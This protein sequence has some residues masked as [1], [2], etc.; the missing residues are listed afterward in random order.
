M[1]Q[2]WRW[3]QGRLEYFRFDNIRIIAKCLLNME[4]ANLNDP[5]LDPLRDILESETGLPFAPSHYKVWR[6]YGRV[7]ACSLLAT[8]HQDLL[9][10]TDLCRRVAGSETPALTVDEY[11]SFIIPR[12]YFPSPV[13]QGYSVSNPQIFPFCA[14]L[15]YL[16]AQFYQRGEANINIDEVF[17]LI[18][19]N[20]DGTENIDF[21]SNLSPSNLTPSGDLKRQ[22]REMLIFI[23]Q[24][25]FLKWHQNALFLDIMPEDSK[26]IEELEAL[27]IPVIKERN[28]SQPDEILAIGTTHDQ[29][30]IAP[31]LIGTRNL[32]TDLIFTEGKQVRVEHIR[33]ERSP[34]LRKLYF[35]MMEEPYLCDMC[36][37][38]AKQRYPWT[39]N[40]LEIHHIL[41]LTSPLAITS[42]GTSLDDIVGVCPNCHRSVHAYYKAWLN[43]HSKEDFDSKP[44]AKEV[45]LEAKER[46]IL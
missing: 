1:I 39:E 12:F 26:S 34:R 5:N 27:T 21:Y 42:R 20:C 25:S 18:G 15:K 19:A 8:R 43:T 37:L 44:E 29:E 2:D 11:L 31:V 24:V 6:N 10:V 4:A 13:F 14:I 23:S 17:S 33:T 40:I 16:I 9:I 7:F 41:P 35:E 38:N 3:D 32:P 36:L 28:S 30:I 22:V 46:V 45:Y